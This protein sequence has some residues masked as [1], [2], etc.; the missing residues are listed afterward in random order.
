MTY[1]SSVG[2]QIRILLG[3]DFSSISVGVNVTTRTFQELKRQD[4]EDRILN[5]QLSQLFSRNWLARCSNI[6]L[7][8]WGRLNFFLESL[9]FLTVS[10]Q[11]TAILHC[12]LLVITCLVYACLVVLHACT[13]LAIFF[14]YGVESFANRLRI[15]T[16]RELRRYCVASCIQMSCVH[17]CCN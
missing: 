1:I 14:S 12:C 9:E 11:Y 2:I 3:Y 4:F 6:G 8:C 5:L 15:Q 7:V 16:A 10:A 13:A 17:A